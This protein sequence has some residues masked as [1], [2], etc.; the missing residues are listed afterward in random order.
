MVDTFDDFRQT[1]VNAGW[2]A[3]N[4]AVYKKE[5]LELVFDTSNY[6]ELYKSGERID[7]ARVE[8]VADVAAFLAKLTMRR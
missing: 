8:S 4:T 6:I 3:I 7:E 1:V 5:G 2:T